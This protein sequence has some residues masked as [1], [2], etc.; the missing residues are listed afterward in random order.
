MNELLL[1]RCALAMLVAMTFALAMGLQAWGPMQLSPAMHQFADERSW[2]GLPHAFNTLASLPLLVM[3]AWGW[4]A[5]AAS[6][7]PTPLRAAWRGFHA[8]MMLS[9]LI[10]AAYHLSPSHALFT[11]A[12]TSTVCAVVLLTCALLG[13]R[14][15]PRFVSPAVR[16]CACIAVAAV[17]LALWL[18][19][20]VVGS[21]DV[22]PLMLLEVVPLL[23]IPAGVLHLPGAQTRPLDWL[24]LLSAYGASKLFE[25]GDAA[26]FNATGWIS[27]HSLMHLALAF[28]TGW[29]AHR[30]GMATG[31][32]DDSPA[33]ASSQRETS[34]N[35]SSL[36]AM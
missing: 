27:G 2:L 6:R 34:L 10:A 4:R 1:K 35:T 21:I 30:A 15:A 14:V 17:G 29:M 19:E 24:M 7:W 22:R 16:S 28:A 32:A 5:T 18:G 13:E 36:D 31:A 23:L 3:G 20:R 8:F 25:L 11:L 26:I 9:A 12:H 33:T